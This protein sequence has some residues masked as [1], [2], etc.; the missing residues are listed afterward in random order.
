MKQLDDLQS[1]LRSYDRRGR[2]MNLSMA[3]FP[4]RPDGLNWEASVS[5][6]RDFPDGPGEIGPTV[7]ARDSDMEVA[8]LKAVKMA[9]AH[10]QEW[11]VGGPDLE[12]RR[13]LRSVGLL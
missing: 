12:T 8:A 9:E 10:Y 6:V 4:Y 11:Y 5:A 1:R 3:W 13:V 2:T 7:T